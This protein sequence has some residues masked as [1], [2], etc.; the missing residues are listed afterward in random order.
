MLKNWSK[1]TNRKK[2]AQEQAQEAETHSFAHG[3]HIYAKDQMQTH[4]GPA[5]MP[6]D[7]EDGS[8]HD[9]S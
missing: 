3:S 5:F 4:A 1:Q 9:N 2:R 6:W 8:K 7:Y